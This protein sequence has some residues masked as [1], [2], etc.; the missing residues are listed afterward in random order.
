MG[1]LKG[2]GGRQKADEKYTNTLQEI[3]Y[4]FEEKTNFPSSLNN[5]ET[6]VTRDV[7]VLPF[8]T[9]SRKHS[10]SVASVSFQS[11]D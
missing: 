8:R 3:A 5:M 1:F 7:P 10:V 6:M 2:G 9:P 4:I 11:L